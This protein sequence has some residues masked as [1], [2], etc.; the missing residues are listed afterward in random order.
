MQPIRITSFRLLIIIIV[1]A[2]KRNYQNVNI[3]SFYSFRRP[4]H[5]LKIVVEIKKRKNRI[6][7]TPSSFIGFGSFF[8]IRF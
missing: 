3:N 8:L 7:L 4:L 6:E 1:D 5:A 2:E